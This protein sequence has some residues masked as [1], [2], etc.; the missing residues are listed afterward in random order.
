MQT[1]SRL[2]ACTFLCL[3]PL[4]PLGARLGYLQVLSHDRLSSRA[5][6]TT[7]RN[8]LEIVPRGRI[9][10]RE[11][12]VLAESLPAWS[13]YLDLGAVSDPRALARKLAPVVSL[14][15][16]ELERRKKAGRRF[17][18]LKRKMTLEE[19]QRLKD[20]GLAAVGSVKD[21]ARHYPNGP[22]ARPLLG[23]VDASGA[24]SAGLERS[25]DK[26]LSGRS[27]QLKVARDGKGLTIPLE[28]GREETPPPDLRLTL[29]R[30][31]Q[32]FAEEEL[33]AALARHGARA[34]AI[35]VQDP[36]NGDVLAMAA[37]P[38]DPLRNAA[39]QDVYEPGSTFKIVMAAAALEKGVPEQRTFDCEGGRWELAPG[40]WVKDHEPKG[41]LTL[42]EVMRHSSNIGSGKIGLELGAA[43]LLRA[44]RAFG[45]G[46]K[47][48]APLPGESAGILRLEDGA[49]ER[50][51]LAN[52]A[53]GQG[54]A[55]TPL[56][57]VGAFSAIANG[58]ELLEPRF[59][60]SVGD[61]DLPEGVR[62]RRVASAA[63]AA[64]LAAM[65]EDVVEKG[66]GKSAA[67]PGWRVAG[68]TGTAQKIDP[69][70]GRYSPVDYVSSFAG[71]A[72]ARGARFSILVVIDSPR[73]KHYASE[74]AAP[75]FARLARR[76]LALRG[77]PPDFPD[78]VRVQHKARPAAPAPSL[79]RPS[80]LEQPKRI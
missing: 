47:T 32:F 19:S 76:V 22:L 68:K 11:G 29:D 30:S 41:P 75:V 37:R 34:G 48:G 72:P 58:G 64:R 78:Q 18:W 28:A 7:S 71:Y 63:A 6:D 50:V 15:A 8:S 59:V 42:L 74:V 9:L 23:A 2:Q 4:G 13:S 57:L 17:L 40:I 24:G 35:I 52:A 31:I 25:F 73:D 79:P 77:V 70:T 55:V 33:S 21:E 39:L 20:L 67:V 38:S 36:A 60:A 80:I 12:R 44:A 16:R 61:R 56:Q 14:D 3:L 49:S 10:D 1:R 46:Y 65:L 66:T 53:F 69:S 54:I 62:V 5:E 27:I 45:F 51:R 43:E 26:S